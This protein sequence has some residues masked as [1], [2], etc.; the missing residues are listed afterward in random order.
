MRFLLYDL[1]RM[2][3]GKALVFLCLLSP[4]IVVFIFST[5]ISPM[6]FTAKGLHFN[7]AICDEDKSDAVNEFITTMVNSQ[8]LADIVTMY[9]VPTVDSGIALVESGD[10]SVFVHIPKGLF[11]SMR[12]G[13]EVKVTIFSTKVHSLENNLI[14]MTLTSSLSVV[15]KS[16]N[17]MEAARYVLLDKGETEVSSEEFLDG[18]I[19]TAIDQ[20][21]N[22]R[23]VLGEG[24]PLSPVGQFLPVEYYVSA[25]FAL[26]AALSMLPL[27]HFSAVDSQGAILRR[28]LL[29]GIGTT[30]F[31]SARIISG[32]IFIFLV[33]TMLF[34]TSMLLRLAGDALGGTYANNFPALTA[35]LVLS[36]LCFSALALT[37]ATWIPSEKT[38]LW[39]GFFLV[40]GMAALC[41]ALIPEGALPKWASVIGRWLPMRASMRMLS[42]SLFDYDKSIFL[43]DMLKTGGFSVIL[44]SLGFFGLKR[45]GRGA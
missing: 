31:F 43:Q 25:I 32:A 27:I 4:I 12:Q 17:I 23:V 35:A 1:K 29:C 20:Y 40:L 11:E 24:G 41:G 16:Q 30:R 44:L 33:Q 3:S 10:V 34:P 45:R 28:G 6:I 26:F 19:S 22:R 36:S 2:F 14:T 7:L 39:T 15:G 18:S 5:V 13:N 38:A 8:A 9:P 21:M 37:I 42:V